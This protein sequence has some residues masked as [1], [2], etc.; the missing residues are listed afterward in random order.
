MKLGVVLFQLGGPD[1]AEAV[2]PFLYNLFSDPEII[3]F[4]L[5]R[6]ARR[7]LARLIASRRGR[8]VAQHYEA[9]GGK[10]PLSEFTRRQAAAL[11]AELEGDFDVKVTIAMRYW[12][13]M[14]EAAVREMQ[15]FGPDRIVLLPLYPQY[16]K[17]TTGSSLKEWNRLYS[18]NGWRTRV[19]LIRE[20]HD[21]PAYV[22]A[23]AAAV[24]DALAGFDDPSGVEI[25][26]TA[27]GVPVEVVEAG[28]PYQ[29]QVERTAELVR[30]KGG[31]PCRTHLCYQS[32]VGPSNWLRPSL[33][34]MLESL[35]AAGARCVLVAPIS[36]VSDHVETLFEI[37]IEHREI[38]E[39]A[40][41]ADFRMTP[42]LNNSPRFIAALAGL[43]R[44]AANECAF[45]QTAGHSATR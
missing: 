42:G 2:E 4:P 11:A 20:Y 44:R 22:E 40:G 30:D 37:D 31:W 6:L 32:K 45:T 8:H 25:V 13:P 15:S 9:I 35:A 12:H 23:V 33:R 3:D 24:G 16:S 14:T 36:F 29:Q 28:D 34:E 26:F 27:H 18:G 43:V 39:R 1:S 38:A 5:A 19:D 7:P 41:I 10:S 21:D 17:T